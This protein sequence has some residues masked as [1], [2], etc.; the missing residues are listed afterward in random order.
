MLRF[1]H[2]GGRG[3]HFPVGRRF[4]GGR[5][6][7]KML[8]MDLQGKPTARFMFFNGMSHIRDKGDI[9]YLENPYIQDNLAFSFQHQLTMAEYYPGLSRGVYL[10]GYR[11]NLHYCPK[12]ILVEVGAQTNTLQEAMN[13]MGPLADVINKVI[14]GTIEN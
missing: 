7:E 4:A 2:F 13:A 6:E 3:A 12:S 8:I 5:Q 14:T 1:W 11:Y 10:K 9:S